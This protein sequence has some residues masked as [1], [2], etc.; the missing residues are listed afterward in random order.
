MAGMNTQARHKAQLDA[1]RAEL[2][3][4]EAALRTRVEAGGLRVLAHG[5]RSRHTAG[6]GGDGAGERAG[7]DRDHLCHR[8]AGASRIVTRRG[9]GG[10]AV[11]ARDQV[12][13]ASPVGEA[14][15]SDTS[16]V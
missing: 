6:S 9:G 7:G 11:C 5:R 1:A 4:A 2:A 10:S 3:A 16:S 13:G 12:T 14:T 8:S 15:I